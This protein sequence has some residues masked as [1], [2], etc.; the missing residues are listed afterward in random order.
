M[1]LRCLCNPGRF[2]IQKLGA[3]N[4]SNSVGLGAH[5]LDE[6]ETGQITCYKSGQSMCS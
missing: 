2:T 3:V 6:N 1:A 4:S 5:L